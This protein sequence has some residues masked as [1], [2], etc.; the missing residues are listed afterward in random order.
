MTIRRVRLLGDPKLRAKCRTVKQP[1]S[2]AARIVI[3]DLRDTLKDLQERHGLGRALAAPQ[4]GAPIRALYVELEEPR[5]MI[6]PE[7]VDVGTDDFQVWDD[8]FSFLDLMVHVQRAYRIKVRYQ[9]LTGKAHTL[10]LEGEAAELI[11]HEIDHLDGVLAVD[12]PMGLD[13]FCQ[14]G[15]WERHYAERGRYG[16]PTPRLAPTDP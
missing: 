7:I 6:N 12:R 2:A 11:Q 9:D 4:V 3:D 15:E 8:C 14:R 16:V 10:E 13:P 5:V 1:K